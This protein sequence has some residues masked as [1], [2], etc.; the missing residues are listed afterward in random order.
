MAYIEEHSTEE[1]LPSKP[2]PQ[3]PA[4]SER[5]SLGPP[6]AQT[7]KPPQAPAS[8]KEIPVVG[9]VFDLGNGL[10]VCS[11]DDCRGK[12][13]HPPPG[14]QW[15]DYDLIDP[16]TTQTLELPGGPHGKNHRYLLCSRRL[17]GFVFKSRK[18]G[19]YSCFFDLFVTSWKLI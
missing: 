1:A 8:Y 14:F 4:G 2:Q 16:L 7:N 3:R 18:W 10:S 12:R 15:T 11:C 17:F 19:E 9:K 6:N 5:V 13:A